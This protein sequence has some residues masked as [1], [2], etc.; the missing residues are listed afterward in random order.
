MSRDIAQREIDLA[1][2]R[3]LNIGAPQAANDATH[4]DA[5]AVPQPPSGTGSPGTSLLAAAAD[6]VHPAQPGTQALLQIGSDDEMEVIG[7][8]EDLVLQKFVDFAPLA[9]GNLTAA[10]SAFVSVD[11][12]D[13]GTFNVRI[14]GTAGMPDGTVVATITTQS[15]SAEPKFA[16]G[17]T[18][19]R[20]SGPTFVKVTGATV[21]PAAT[22][23]IADLRITLAG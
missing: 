7:P 13:T 11:S 17:Q 6:H 19:P 4:V 23:R 2:F 21:N 12:A 9:S 18:I 15:A 20:P 10:F 22:A 16:A 8:T 14:G 1:G 5:Q 3:I